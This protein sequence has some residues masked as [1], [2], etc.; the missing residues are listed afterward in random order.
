MELDGFN[1]DLLSFLRRS[2]SPF[3]AVDVLSQTLVDGGFVRLEEEDAWSLKSGGRYFFVRDGSIV[4]FVYGKN[5]PV[6]SGIRFV[7]AHTD[8]P[9]LKVKPNADVERCG[10]HQLAVAV[11]GGALLHPWFDRDL[12]LAGQVVYRVGSEQRSVLVDFAR[13][14]A[15]VPSLAIH[16]NRDANKASSVNPQSDILPIVWQDSS[17]SF[18]AR[19]LDCV[20]EQDAQAEVVLAHDLCFY[21]CQAPALVGFDDEFVASARLDNL[22]SCF[23]GLQALLSAS[24]DESCVLVCYDHE[25][26]GSVSHSG[27]Q[28]PLVESLLSRWFSD[29]V[30]RE[31]ALSQSWLV[32]VDNAHAVHPNFSDKH[33]GLHLPLLN[34]GP[35][36]KVNH[37]LRY[38]TSAESA[39]FFKGLCEGVDVPVQSFVVRNDMG[40]GSTIGPLAASQL[41]VRTVDVGLPSLAMHSIRELAGVKD[42]FALFRVLGRFFQ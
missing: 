28:S 5:S 21:D 17:Q 6:E 15:V 7:G 36:I 2:P 33:D 8:S 24:G 34:G 41:G 23:V 19:L 1:Q 14:V 32:S 38:A 9:C 22:L 27:A 25:E 10:V 26:V 30:D 42:G 31:R 18:E 37:N 4:A 40:C 13:P 35:V 11:Y 3:H 12:S 20:K 29:V 16:L 39:G